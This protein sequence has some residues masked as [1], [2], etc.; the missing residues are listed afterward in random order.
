MFLKDFRLF[1]HIM[2]KNWTKMGK[3]MNINAIMKSHVNPNSSGIQS[4]C[5]ICGT[6]D[7]CVAIKDALSA[8]FNDYQH[9][10]FGSAYICVTC[11]ACMRG[12]GVNGKALRNYSF[13]ATVDELMI[14]DKRGIVDSIA[15]PPD[16]EFIFCVSFTRK[17]HIFLHARINPG[18]CEDVYIA[19]DKRDIFINRKEFCELFDACD[20]LYQAGFNKSEIETGIYKKFSVIE[21]LPEFHLLESEVKQHRGNFLLHF[22]CHVLTKER[23]DDKN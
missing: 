5:A 18:G 4:R 7:D 17:K 12:D 3:L 19:T 22:V 23:E 16:K 20:K 6:L 10:R 8:K 21:K 9:L 11:H 14:L 1:W 15:I 13:I 2:D